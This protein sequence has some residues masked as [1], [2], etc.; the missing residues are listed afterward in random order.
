[1]RA[2]DEA[3]AL[4]DEGLVAKALASRG[5]LAFARTDLVEAERLLETALQWERANG[6]PRTAALL[7]TSLTNTAE[8]RTDLSA[9]RKRCE[10]S[11][12]L[13]ETLE[14]P[15]SL[16]YALH[17]LAGLTL[18]DGEADRARVLSERALRLADQVGNRWTAAASRTLLGDIAI[19]RES[20]AEADE[21]LKASLAIFRE[22]RDSG[23]ILRVLYR[24]ARA[25]LGAGDSAASRES[26]DE[27]LA[28][29]RAI[30]SP[31]DLLYLLQGYRDLALAADRFGHAARLQGAVVGFAERSRIDLWPDE[32]QFLSAA[33]TKLQASLEPAQLARC[34]AEGRALER[35]ALYPLCSAE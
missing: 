34:L 7:L 20:W 31:R 3:T 5:H 25:A 15:S 27:A 12:R 28:I 33:A 16:A 10:E 35:A 14:D 21:H 8:M 32:T 6:D 29:E 26:L 22:L 4:A 2:H 23:T 17:R 13:L 24:L 1:V 18:K 9:A 30:D 11:L 19:S